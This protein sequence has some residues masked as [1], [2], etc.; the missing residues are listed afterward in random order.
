MNTALL[1][2]AASAAAPAAIM[3]AVI[4]W[5]RIREPHRDLRRPFAIGG[6]RDYRD[7]CRRVDRLLAEGDH[8]HAWIGCLAIC[9]WLKSERHYGSLRRKRRLSAALKT[10]TARKQEFAPFLD[11]DPQ[12]DLTP[13][14]VPAQ[15]VP[16]RAIRKGRLILAT[17][18]CLAAG[19][20][21]F[22]AWFA[23]LT[24]RG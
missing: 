16:A 15:Q 23:G 8:W 11:L 9:E 20:L 24:L 3:G 13:L 17:G 12:A 14:R 18:Y 4:A 21:V 7:A 1:A 6:E 2:G 22:A 10:W 5:D 19:V